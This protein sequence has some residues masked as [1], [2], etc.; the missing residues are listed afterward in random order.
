MNVK[1]I[2]ESEIH[3]SSKGHVI[4]SPDRIL[5]DNKRSINELL[6]QL[7]NG[8]D[9]SMEDAALALENTFKGLGG[10]SDP[11]NYE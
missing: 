3:E 4:I 8:Y 10:G 6:Q 9:I 11:R 5:R 1:K 2:I 7:V